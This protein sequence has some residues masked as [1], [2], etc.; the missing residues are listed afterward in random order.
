VNIKSLFLLFS[1]VFICTSVAFS[2]ADSLN[3]VISKAPSDSDRAAILI[4]HTTT[5]LSQFPDSALK[6]LQEA[7]KYAVKSGN[8]GLMIDIKSKMGILSATHSDFLNSLKFFQQ[9]L[10][11]AEDINDKPKISS[12]YTNIANIYVYLNIFD[13]ANEYYS[14]SI[15]IK[16]KIKDRKNL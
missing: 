2:N 8:Y 6:T 15:E 7:Y 13:K 9:M 14:K 5:F 10:K 16:E 11:L 3:I 4:K 12:A 1:I